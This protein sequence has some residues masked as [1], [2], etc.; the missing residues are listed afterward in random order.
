MPIFWLEQKFLMDRDKTSQ[1]KLALN[2]PLLGQIVGALL[3]FTGFLVMSIN[4]FRRFFCAN[5]KANNL[6][7]KHEVNGHSAVIRD[8]SNPLM[9]KGYQVD[10]TL[11][12][13]TKD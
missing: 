13:I 3:I 1:V 12:E 5:E 9:N 10:S 6:P 2:A 4:Q 8:E 7:S 11:S